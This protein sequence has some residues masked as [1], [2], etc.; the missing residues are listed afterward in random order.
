MA[1]TASPEISHHDFASPRELHR[2]RSEPG[3]AQ[4]SCSGFHCFVLTAIHRR[5][6]ILRRPTGI[7]DR[8]CTVHND[9]CC[10]SYCG[11]SHGRP[12]TIMMAATRCQA[13]QAF[14]VRLDRSSSES[15]SKWPPQSQSHDHL[16][17]CN[18]HDSFSVLQSYFC[19]GRQNAM[20]I[21]CV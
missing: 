10:L 16:F 19:S 6:V 12:V 7:I 2:P 1:P 20:R 9:A 5:L 14:S 11:P 8:L 21:G 4:R 13:W 15:I 3:S 17:V 18:V